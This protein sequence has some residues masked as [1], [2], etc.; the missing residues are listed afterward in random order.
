MGKLVKISIFLTAISASVFS[1]PSQLFYEKVISGG[2]NIVHVA[3]LFDSQDE[4]NGFVY[5]DTARNKIVLDFLHSDTT[6]AI[7][8][9]AKPL[10]TIIRYSEL[11]DTLY[12]YTLTTVIGNKPKITLTTYYEDSYT[13]LTI[14]TPTNLDISFEAMTT[15][16]SIKHFD[17][18]FYPSNK[19]PQQIIY[20][21]IYQVNEY[22]VTMGFETDNNSTS[23][24]YD[25]E[26]S[27]V[28][29]SSTQTS[30][31]PGNLFSLE[32]KNYLYT[33]LYFSA[34]DNRDQNNEGDRSISSYQKLLIFDEL[35]N[36]NS[37]LTADSYRIYSIFVDN[38]APS[39]L[40]DE[41]IIHANSE[42]LLGSY[43]KDKHIACYSFADGSPEE[44]WYNNDILDIDF[45]YIYKAEDLLVGTRNSNKV[46]MLNYLNGQVTDSTVLDS[47]LRT[48]QFF[49]TGESQPILNIV[50]IS[51]DTL[52]VFRFDISTG[53]RDNSLKYERPLTFSLFQNH[54]N[55]FNGDTRF[56]FSN[57]ESQYLK[58]SIF[59]ILGQEIKVLVSSRF[60][61]GRYSYY[62]NGSDE[63]GLS[64]STG[65]YFA[66]LESDIASQMI[67]LIYLK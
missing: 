17:I 35:D 30:I 58:L 5:T 53:I 40:T 28:L 21:W 13:Q 44:L 51:S 47:P 33:E 8:I 25:L 10:K 7:D 3:P 9:P 23:L 16:L 50:G 14:I 39:S 62:W 19:N 65:I 32:S 48:I 29:Q 41:L 43:D 42:D 36:L 54:P 6:I 37:Q 24:V 31:Y 57:E 22:F 34:Y 27:E 2:E 59:N 45:S 55:P 1:A 18:K 67:K 46:M 56:E 64:Q 66:R 20:E 12:L 11:K 4:L 15:Y 26:L 38:F 63:N 61:P 49:E 60:S 52:K